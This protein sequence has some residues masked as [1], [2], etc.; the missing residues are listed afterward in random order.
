[1]AVIQL[2]SFRMDESD[3]VSA[4]ISKLMELT[5]AIFIMCSSTDGIYFY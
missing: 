4:T 1:M 3:L 2:L 5:A